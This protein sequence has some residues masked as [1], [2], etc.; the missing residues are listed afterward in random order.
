MIEMEDK[1]WWVLGTN[2]VWGIE[3][4][5]KF[6]ITRKHNKTCGK[7][8]HTNKHIHSTWMT[9]KNEHVSS[10]KRLN[11]EEFCWECVSSSV[12]TQI[13]R[14]GLYRQNIMFRTLLPHKHR[15]VHILVLLPVI[16]GNNGMFLAKGPPPFK[17][18]SDRKV[19]WRSS[20]ET[21]HIINDGNKRSGSP[22]II[23]HEGDITSKGQHAHFLL[24]T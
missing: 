21:F 18:L 4:K 9:Q 8:N 17:G 20:P 15:H 12:E 14:T 16:Q 23:G 7:W 6:I 19:K 3:H 22:P 13:L 24:R 11:F 2:F 10:L 1:C 5:L